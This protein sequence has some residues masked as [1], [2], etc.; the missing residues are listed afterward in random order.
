MKISRV[1]IAQISGALQNTEYSFIAA[2]TINENSVLLTALLEVIV[3]YSYSWSTTAGVIFGLQYLC[4]P[5]DTE[6]VQC[7]SLGDFTSLSLL[8]HCQQRDNA[9]PPAQHL[10]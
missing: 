7:P 6:K 3:F 2:K 8:S 4:A 10:R 5:G 1:H 9:E